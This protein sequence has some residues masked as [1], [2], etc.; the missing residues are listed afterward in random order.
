MIM[1]P[2][3]LEFLNVGIRVKAGSD[4]KWQNSLTYY[5]QHDF[6]GPSSLVFYS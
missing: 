3:K 5:A 1:D 6:K 2:P 4:F